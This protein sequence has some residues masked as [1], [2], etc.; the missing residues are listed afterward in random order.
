MNDIHVFHCLKG[1]K[2]RF[3]VFAP[4][5]GNAEDLRGGTVTVFINGGKGPGSSLTV[6]LNPLKGSASN[7]EKSFLGISGKCKKVWATVL[8]PG[9]KMGNLTYQVKIGTYQ[10]GIVMITGYS[11]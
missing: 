2:V 5:N 8:I 7:E 1:A 6:K 4:V 11:S 3:L 10:S 9:G